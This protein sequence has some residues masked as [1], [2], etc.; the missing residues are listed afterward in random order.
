MNAERAQTLLQAERARIDALLTELDAQDATLRSE[1]GTVD[2][3]GDGAVKLATVGTQG[4]VTDSLRARL[5]AVDRA[6]Q[7]LAAGTYGKSVRSGRPIPDARLEA[8]P[9]AE[10]LVDEAA[11]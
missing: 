5:E 11:K 8:D 6:E 2:D 4:L 7:R 9:A 10:L 1:S 3:V